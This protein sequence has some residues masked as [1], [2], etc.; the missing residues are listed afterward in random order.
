MSETEVLDRV[1]DVII[2]ALEGRAAKNHDCV[3]TE[4]IRMR[5]EAR[6]GFDVSSLLKFQPMYPNSMYVPSLECD[7]DRL[8]ATS[9]EY[10]VRH[11]ADTLK[12]GAE[13]AF[14]YK[15]GLKWIG[16]RRTS[17]P[18]NLYELGGACA[19]YEAHFRYIFLNGASSYL[20]RV[21]AFSET[22]NQCPVKTRIGNVLVCSR[23]EM[24]YFFVPVSVIEDTHRAQTM[25][26]TVS[27]A[28]E[29]K[30]SVPLDDYKQMFSSRN[31]PMQNGR[32][33]AI[34]HWVASHLRKRRDKDP[35]RVKKHV[36]GVDRIEIDGLKISI[37]P[38]DV[39]DL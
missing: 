23:S 26:A 8:Y 1:E 16:L 31:A 6:Q 15:G 37:S 10:L 19:W 18:K 33:K 13:V 5:G 39:G 36:R 7:N 35:V 3:P 25:L 34:I 21:I 24:E 11:P 17:K 30:F 2:Y 20:K 29:I 22:G 9:S 12:D 28:A 4:T 14:I 38:N 27:D 32:R